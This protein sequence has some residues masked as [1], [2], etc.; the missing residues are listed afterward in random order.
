MDVNIIFAPMTY[1][2]C[3]KIKCDQ[4]I[5]SCTIV[6]EGDCPVSKLLLEI[7]TLKEI[8]QKLIKKAL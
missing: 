7:E 5:Y 2:M 4:C 1:E 3:H 8:N 6:H